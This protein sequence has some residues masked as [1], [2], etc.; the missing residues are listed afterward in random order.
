MRSY[1]VG[2]DVHSKKSAFVIEDERGKVIA[3]GQVGDDAGRVFAAAGDPSACA[4]N[5]GRPGNR[6]RCLLRR[7]PARSTGV[8]PDCGPRAR[9]AAQ[10]TPTP[11][12]RA[13]GVTRSSSVR[14]CGG[15]STVR[16]STFRVRRSSV[17]ATVSR[18]YQGRVGRRVGPRSTG[19]KAAETFNDSAACWV[20]RGG[21]LEPPR[22]L[23][24]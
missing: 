14:V 5:P 7:P 19:R 2:L 10:G 22:V 6:D 21:G 17:C 20:M 12:R 1:Y 23:P 3:Q 16:S 13:M 15:E 11:T 9:G 8:R 4:R 24:H 18:R